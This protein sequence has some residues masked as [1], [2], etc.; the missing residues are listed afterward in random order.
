MKL[1]LTR[2]ICWLVLVLLGFLPLS[3]GRD[4]VSSQAP[5]GGRN[6][7]VDILIFVDSSVSI[8]NS[9]P[10]GLRAEVIRRMIGSI[11]SD[12]SL[13]EWTRVGV[14]SFSDEARVMLPLDDVSAIREAI[15]GLDYPAA[16]GTDLLSA[17]QGGIQVFDGADTF[18]DRKPVMLF[19]TDGVPYDRR[20][21]RE[22]GA[23]FLELQ[24]YV[25]ERLRLHGCAVYVIVIDVSGGCVERESRWRDVADAVFGVQAEEQLNP[26]LEGVM[27]GIYGIPPAVRETVTPERELTFPV[28]P[29]SELLEAYTLG[30]CVDS[31]L[32][33]HRPDGGAVECTELGASAEEHGACRKFMVTEPEPGDWTFRAV[34]G[35]FAVYRKLVS[36]RLRLVKPDKAHPLGKPMRV[37]VSF[38]DGAIRE[39]SA[40]K[41]RLSGRLIAPDGG[42]HGLEFAAKAD[43]G[44]VAR[45]AVIPDVEGLFTLKLTAHG[46]DAFHSETVETITV[47]EM[48]YI[49]IHKPAVAALDI[50]GMEVQASLYR[51][52]ERLPE[53]ELADVPALAK[54]FCPDGEVKAAWLEL[55][56]GGVFRG[57]FGLETKGRYR[58]EVKTA[59]SHVAPE[60]VV[61]SAKMSPLGYVRRSAVYAGVG[62]ASLLLLAVMAL[63]IRLCTYPRATG[64]ISG[65]PASGGEALLGRRRFYRKRWGFLRLKKHGDTRGRTVLITGSS[66]NA[67]LIWCWKGLTVARRRL[68]QNGILNIGRHSLRYA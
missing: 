67:V 16:G 21:L 40:Y 42:E 17:L 57:S 18:S 66:G 11:A 3:C 28:P 36:R 43:G 1:K 25:S 13:S 54:L 12:A 31:G 56:P 14:M 32:T 52:S 20:K 50:G 55:A 41:L 22:P 5:L 37:E 47:S 39:L 35:E 26:A 38:L 7:P 19:L 60:A 15:G 51:G 23:Y 27:Q 9:D 58:L 44:Y 24:A 68:S 4:R 33:L 29:Y 48:P 64:S 8:A 45:S 49:V 63:F 6:F 46:G 34:G 10:E 65:Y 61:F 2:N 30:A 59:D 53:Q 62:I